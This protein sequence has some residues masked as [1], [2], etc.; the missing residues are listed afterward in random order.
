MR[1]TEPRRL[2]IEHL[3]GK[4]FIAAMALLFT[5]GRL[6]LA[7][8]PEDAQAIAL[9]VGALSVPVG[10]YLGIKVASGER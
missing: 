2:L 4:K 3:G 7:W 10:L 1:N 5:G 8:G 6:A 9:V